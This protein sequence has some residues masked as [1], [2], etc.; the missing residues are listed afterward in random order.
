MRLLKL[1][2]LILVVFMISRT[3]GSN[4]K[5]ISIRFNPRPGQIFGF[6]EP[7]RQARVA[8]L[9]VSKGFGICLRANIWTWNINII[10]ESD[11]LKLRFEAYPLNQALFTHANRQYTFSHETILPYTRTAWNSI[12][13]TYNATE[14]TD[15]TFTL[16]INGQ[17]AYYVSGPDL[18]MT[19]TRL[20]NTTLSLGGGYFTGRIADVLVW[21]RPLSYEEILT[22]S[23]G[24]DDGF[25]VNSGP[26]QI[27]WPVFNST[28]DVSN[29]TQLSWVHSNSF[30]ARS[31]T[32][33][34][35]AKIFTIQSFEG[36]YEGSK[37][38]QQI[39]GKVMYPVDEDHWD[40]ILGALNS[41]M[42]QT[43]CY[44]KFWIPA[45]R[46]GK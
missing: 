42:V 25:L 28:Y 5:A 40:K 17:L 15:L 18:T 30:C 20:T 27:L 3:M 8:S 4:D 31:K 23:D 39:N 11:L 38:C 1:T 32:W 36:L 7:F 46:S 19:E 35:G 10:T 37:V 45:I 26:V 29:Y 22:Y 43:K 34:Q 16:M 41:S 6:T 2:K 21:N 33:N 13:A 9:D 24:C 14:S 44:N 12:C